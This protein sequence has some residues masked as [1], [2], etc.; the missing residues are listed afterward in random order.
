MIPHPWTYSDRIMDVMFTHCTGLSSQISLVNKQAAGRGG[1]GE[2]GRAGAP[3]RPGGGRRPLPEE[4]AR[5]ATGP[6]GGLENAIH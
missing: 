3:P 4:G 5:A 2:G 1:E 6:G